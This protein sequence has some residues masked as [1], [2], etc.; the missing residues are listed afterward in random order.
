VSGFILP[1]GE[2]SKAQ[3][4]TGEAELGDGSDDGPQDN[5]P[6]DNDAKKDSSGVFA[7]QSMA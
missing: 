4:E 7:D 5:E 2:G 3:D 6:D 1:G